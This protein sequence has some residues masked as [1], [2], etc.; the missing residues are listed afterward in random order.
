MLDLINDLKAVIKLIVNLDTRPSLFEEF[1]SQCQ[2]KLNCLEDFYIS[3]IHDMFH[4]MMASFYVLH[5]YKGVILQKN[6]ILD[7]NKNLYFL[8][9]VN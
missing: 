2:F 1:Y 6:G 4:Q 7:R 3:R 8:C 9:S 5:S